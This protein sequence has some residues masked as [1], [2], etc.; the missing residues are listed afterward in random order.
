MYRLTTSVIAGLAAVNGALAFGGPDAC[1]Q[2]GYPA[3]GPNYPCNEVQEWNVRCNNIK[4]L[5][6]HQACICE[7]WHKDN[8]EGCS[9]CKLKHGIDGP[10]GIKYWEAVNDKALQ[11]YCKLEKP[12][13]KYPEFWA[14]VQNLA[15]PPPMHSNDGN[16]PNNVLGKDISVGRYYTPKVP[17]PDVSKYSCNDTAPTGTAKVPEFS[18]VAVATQTATPAPS[19]TAMAAPKYKSNNSSVVVEAKAAVSAKLSLVSIGYKCD[20]KVNGRE[21]VHWD[22]SSPYRINNPKIEAVAYA[23]IEAS[24]A[25]NLLDASFCGCVPNQLI[26]GENFKLENKIEGRAGYTVL[27][28]SKDNKEILRPRSPFPPAA[29]AKVEAKA[30]AHATVSGSSEA[31][32]EAKASASVTIA[33]QGDCKVYVPASSVQN[34]K[35]IADGKPAA[36]PHTVPKAPAPAPAPATTSAGIPA[37]RP[38]GTGAPIV[39]TS[40]KV[41]PP[42]D[43]ISGAAAMTVPALALAAGILV[44]AF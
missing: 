38:A 25:V 14:E 41:A 30:E 42:A 10:Q 13:K 17:K 15:G 4:N 40:P 34:G 18:V 21:G 39:P 22:C 32:A 7:P 2:D 33:T 12:D 6:T 8:V 9:S 19:A 27:K 1:H 20:A 29:V 31:H 16:L 36:L 44:A 28:P 5:K 35:V 43:I 23:K 37:A 11:G 3:S 26:T 24:I